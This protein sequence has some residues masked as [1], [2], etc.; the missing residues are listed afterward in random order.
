[1]HIT[2]IFVPK[3][4]TYNGRVKSREKKKEWMHK[5]RHNNTKHQIHNVM[6]ER[7]KERETERINTI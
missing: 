7:E 2:H 3:H 5:T 6:D 4:S 1:M